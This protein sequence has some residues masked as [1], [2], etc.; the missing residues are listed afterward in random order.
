MS[1]QIWAWR[2]KYN[3]ELDE[4]I[5]RT[6][7]NIPVQLR[8]STD[9][10]TNVISIS[11][12]NRHSLALKADG[13]V[14]AWGSNSNGQLGDGTSGTNKDIPVQVKDATDPTGFLT[15]VIAVFASWRHSL[16]LKIDGTV[17][18]WGNNYD[19]QLGDATSGSN[20]NMPVQVK[21]TTDPTGFLTNV[22]TISAG[23]FHSLALK[24]DGTVWAWG[25]NSKGQLGNGTSGTN[26]KIPVQVKDH[27]AFLTNVIAVFASWSHSLALKADGT[28][29][30]WGNN[31]DGQLGD[32]TFGS[33]KNIPVQVKD[34]TDP[35]GFLTN[36]IDISG[37]WFHSLALKTNGTVW[38]WGG[39]SSGQLGDGTFGSNKNIPVQVKDP[40]GFLTNVTSISA[41]WSHSLVLKTNGTVW[42]WSRNIEGQLGDGTS[43]SNKNI[44]VQV[45]V[46]N[47]FMTNVIAISAGWSHSLAL[48]TDGTVWAWGNNY[49]GQLG[50]GTLGGNKNTPVQVKD[51]TN[52]FDFITN[53]MAISTGDRY[54]T[55]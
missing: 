49:N 6:N 24:A 4:S 45:K 5:F 53:V 48:K 2:N 10:L 30:T 43:G 46:V 29:W 18:A 35:T 51:S 25:N 14:W 3:G 44:P 9:F 7:K 20:K 22:T 40:T 54:F 55:S 19:G 17:W 8:G 32:G 28:V 31:Y 27:T 13:T 47:G 52:P 41:G 1:N 39:N 42:G 36:V 26:E 16:A 50:D 15:N 33:N 37:G 23:W 38:A 21:D 34:T 11:A 12:G